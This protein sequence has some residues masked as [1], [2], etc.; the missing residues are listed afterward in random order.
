MT[1]TAAEYEGVELDYSGSGRGCG[2]C[3]SLC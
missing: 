2:G 3:M 1:Y